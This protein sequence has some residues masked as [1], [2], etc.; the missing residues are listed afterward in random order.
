L[1]SSLA[2]SLEVSQE[3]GFALLGALGADCAGAVAVLPRGQ[4]PRDGEGDIRPLDEAELI[5]LIEELPEHPLGI[6]GR[7]R[8]VR[9]SL[10][11]IQ[12][13]LVLVRSPNG[14]YGQP[15]EG[16]PSTCILKPGHE[17]Y[18]EIVAN[19][20]FCLRLASSAG[21]DAARAEPVDVGGR[22]CLLVERFDR[23]FAA[24]GRISRLHQEDMCQALRIDP[25]DKYETSGG[26]SIVAI[27]RLLRDTGLGP[28][29][30]RHSQADRGLCCSTS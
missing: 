14:D 27:V 1:R 4:R 5:R 18:P 20:A 23:T 22:P 19:E 2:H 6:D 26:P 28:G 17:D 12:E 13:K 8:G 16:A 30:P 21:L 7:A 9:L 11:G 25:V 3:D 10:G 15:L 24:G 29:R